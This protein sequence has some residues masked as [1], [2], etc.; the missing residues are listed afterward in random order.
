[1]NAF[2]FKPY[3]ARFLLITCYLALVTALSVLPAQSSIVA[4]TPR[5]SPTNTRATPRPNILWILGDDLGRQL[6]CYGTPL[7]R[8][9]NIDRLA[10]E[11]ARYTNAFTTAP[12]CSPSRSAL[13]TGMYQTTIG[14]HDHRSHQNDGY[15]LPS[16]VK[17]LTDHFRKAGYFT[18]NVTTPAPGLKV[19]GK[20]DFNFSA[21]K[22]FDGTDWNQS[23]PG[24]PF[25]AQVNFFEP[26]RTSGGYSQQPVRNQKHTVDPAKVRLPPYFPDHPVV[27]EDWADYLNAIQILDAKVGAVLDRLE[28]EGLTDNTVVMFFS[29]NG[30]CH[31]RGKVWLYDAGIHIP[32]IIRYPKWIKAGTVRD[33]L[34]SSIDITATALSLAG[35]LVPANMQGQVFLGSSAR[36]REYI[37]AA[38]DRCGE[39]VDR[40]RAV[41]SGRYK[42]IR[43]YRPEIPYAQPHNYIDTHYP[44]LGILRQFYQEGRLN[45]VQ[46]LFMQLR[47]PAEE[48]YDTATD[49]YEVNNL[50]ASVK[51]QAVRN[52][53]GQALDGWMKAY[54][55]T[56][57]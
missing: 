51:H 1:M 37:F 20:T 13:I 16:N 28:R 57:H 9:P 36:Q 25:Y 24:Q 35:I 11:G 55:R 43:N 50:A 2:C 45:T 23:A 17:L 33:E 44:T 42:L 48:L 10:R 46:S 27:R 39:A 4:R 15:T 26:H 41:R 18:A 31:I 49:P 38:R 21:P 54:D 32:L 34:V 30:Q 52:E 5:Q 6:G 53:L 56:Q 22:P 40:V 19:A 14:A 47:K 12:V 8:T 3:S 29:D 7:V